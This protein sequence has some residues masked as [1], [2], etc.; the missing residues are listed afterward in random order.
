MPGTARE[1]ICKAGTVQIGQAA[2]AG[3]LNVTLTSSNPAALL[4]SPAANVA[5]SAS[6]TVTI[7]AGS[8]IGSY[9]LQALTDTGTASYTAHATNYTDKTSTFSL[10]TRASFCSV[11]RVPDFPLTTH[12][13]DP[14]TNLAVSDRGAQA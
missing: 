14:P 6:I 2:P 4:I 11:L 5:G 7:P 12:V 8:N 3:G 9:Y 1:R 10:P 13:G